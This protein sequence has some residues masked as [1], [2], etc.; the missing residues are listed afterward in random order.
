M[1]SPWQ[2]VGPKPKIAL[3]SSFETIRNHPWVHLPHS[4]LIKFD[5]IIDF[6]RIWPNGHSSSSHSAYCQF[7]LAPPTHAPSPILSS[8]STSKKNLWRLTF[9]RDVKTISGTFSSLTLI[10]LQDF[11]M[12][13]CGCL[14]VFLCVSMGVCRG[15]IAWLATCWCAQS[16]ELSC[17]SSSSGTICLSLHPTPSQRLNRSLYV[18]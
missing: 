2:P 14:W 8:K 6:Y 5:Y 16:T 9:E 7:D 15:G 1:R 18:T 11:A 3:I 17:A 12:G 10:S 13:V 4:E